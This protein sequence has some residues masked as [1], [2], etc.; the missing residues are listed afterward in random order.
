M[1]VAEWI[2]KSLAGSGRVPG[3][4]PLSV[5]EING[6]EWIYVKECLDKGWVSS[7]GSYVTKFEKAM[8][9]VTKTRF[10]VATINGTAALHMALLVAG[11]RPGDEVL[12]PALTFVATA[13]AVSYCG[14]HPVFIDVS[15]TNW[16]LDPEKM[17]QFLETQCRMRGRHLVNKVTGRTLRAVIPVHLLGHP[18]D[19]DPLLAVSKRYHLTVIEDACESLG[20]RYKG[21]P[22]GSLG[23][24]ACFSFNGNK[25]VTTGGGGMIVSNK[26]AWAKQAKYLTTQAK[27]HPQEYIHNHIGYNYRLTN[28]SA[29]MGCAQIERLAEFRKKKELIAKRYREGFDHMTPIGFQPT[30]SW[31]DSIHW[32]FTIRLHPSYAPPR[33][34]A[35]LKSRKIES[36]RLWRPL[37]RLPMYKNNPSGDIVLAHALYRQC[38]SLPSSIGLTWSDQKRVIKEV[39]RFVQ[40]R[41]RR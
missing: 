29:A 5:P 40:K 10:A 9:K 23:D 37:N 21:R 34:I 15:S 11:V 24:I 16:C 41:T 33:L 3:W 14:A 36:R 26:D 17:R 30:A 7:V 27:D 22:A 20:A 35:Y 8:A 12:V 1:L 4:I 18:V 28:L 19:M 32:L 13:N 2:L 31:A 38:V 6:K 39:G 25:M